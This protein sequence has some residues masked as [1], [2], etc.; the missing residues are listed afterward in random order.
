ME[1]AGASITLFLLDPE[2]ED[3]LRA[4]AECAFWKVS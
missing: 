4:P 2:L 1:M 3:L